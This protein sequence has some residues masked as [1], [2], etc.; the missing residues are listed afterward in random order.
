MPDLQQRNGGFNDSR[1][2]SSSTGNGSSTGSNAETLAQL[3]G[4]GP[5]LPEQDIGKVESGSAFAD[6]AGGLLDAAAPG[7]GSSLQFKLKADIPLY[8][9]P[10][11]SVD[12]KPSMT[13]GVE[14]KGGKMIS[15]MQLAAS[16]GVS[17]GVETWLIDFQAALEASF[18]GTLK[19]TGDDGLEVFD[20]FLLSLRYVIES[21]CDSVSM[22]DNF[23][24]SIIN[25]IMSENEVE[26]VVEGMDDKDQ[27]RMEL[28][29]GLTG[30]ASAGAVGA[31]ASASV[32]HAMTLQN[33][34]N[35][36]LT[37]NENTSTQ[38]STSVNIGPFTAERK[39]MNGKTI[40]TMSASK[41]FPIL[42]RDVNGSVKLQFENEI[43]KKAQ[44]SGSTEASISLDELS[45]MMFGDDGWLRAIKD[46]VVEGL[47]N[48]NQQIDNPLL[49]MIAGSL[50][51]SNASGSDAVVSEMGEVVGESANN[52]T[53]FD[54]EAKIKVT[55]DLM[56]QRGSGFSFKITIATNNSTKIGFGGN[57]VE[58]TQNDRL[59]QLTLGNGGLSVDFS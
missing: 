26:D 50:G 45:E 36:N 52:G 7:E 54:A 5:E 22:P 48:L 6:M 19:I 42:G 49:Q 44:L 46:G 14:R 38:A 27:V 21:A 56:W 28:S 37:M 13:M 40:D 29:A 30:R 32:K 43:L 33:D 16:V 31:S 25:G 23:K 12:F 55:T 24:S 51:S 9:S 2:S 57:T 20:Q 53:S 4:K 18:S 34:G 11:I 47:V 8:K 1:H 10:G 3:Q 59:M 58:I 41:S 39:W 17:A 15:T 35:D